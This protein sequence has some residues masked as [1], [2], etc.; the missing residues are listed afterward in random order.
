MPNRTKFLALIIAVI[1][2]VP[3]IEAALSGSASA[4][5]ITTRSLTLQAGV[6]DGGSKPS[7]NVNHLFSFTIPT[8]GNIGSI[9]FQ[10]CTTAANSPAFPSCTTPAGLS[11]T[12]ATMGSQSG[13]TGFTLNNTTNGAPYITRSAAL[14]TSGQAVTYQLLGVVNPDATDCPANAA[15]PSCTFFVRITTYASTNTTGAVTDSGTVAAS[16]NEQI[17][18]TGT[19]P[20][21]LVFCTGGTVGTTSSV[22]DCATATSGAV[23]FNQLFSPT[24]TATA[25]SQMA[26]STNAGFG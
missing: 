14:I 4:A 6:T 21:S 7:G 10:Y 3:L 12:S 1:M 24:D 13:A 18:L 25:T 19:M 15:A 16:V 20:E 5:Q 17:T 22:P 2:L 9:K 11:T 8:T 26:A 23:A